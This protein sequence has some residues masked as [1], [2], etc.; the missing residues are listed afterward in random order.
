MESAENLSIIDAMKPKPGE[1]EII[2]KW[3]YENSKVYA[4]DNCKRIEWLRQNYLHEIN[5]VDGGW[6]T[7][8]QD[9]QDKRY[10]QHTYP[11]GELQGGG[12]PIL[13]CVNVI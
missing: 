9:P 13:K 11:Q 12:P 4:D 10:W 6:T 5:R 8:Y 1:T 2:G 3:L 7:N